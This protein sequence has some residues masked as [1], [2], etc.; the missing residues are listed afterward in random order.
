MI[1]VG[2]FKRM[3]RRTVTITTTGTVANDESRDNYKED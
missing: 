3:I 1:K 2:T